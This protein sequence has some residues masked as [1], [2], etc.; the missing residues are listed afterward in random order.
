MPAC[1]SRPLG[2]P[3]VFGS[4]R[5]E[6][7]GELGSRT[8]KGRDFTAS[9]RRADGPGPDGSGGESGGFQPGV[10]HGSR[11]CG[12]D[13]SLSTSPPSLGLGVLPSPDSC[14]L[15]EG[16]QVQGHESGPLTPCRD[17]VWPNRKSASVSWCFGVPLPVSPP[18][19]SDPLRGKGPPAT[20]AAPASS[21]PPGPWNLP[22]PSAPP[23]RVFGPNLLK[24]SVNDSPPG[25]VSPSCV[26]LPGHSRLRLF[27]L[28]EL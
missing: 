17:T 22:Q 23:S 8:G 3:W 21:P 13:G 26:S 2:R 9:R 12:G 14:A 27:V 5:A 24:W 15:W 19:T 25:R 20:W 7:S 6:P 10:C 18:P 28:V 1:S 4:L 11:G 16:F